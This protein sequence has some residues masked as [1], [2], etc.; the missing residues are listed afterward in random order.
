MASGHAP[1]K[2]QQVIFAELEAVAAKG[3]TSRELQKA[4]A[5]FRWQIIEMLDDPADI[6]EFLGVEH[7]IGLARSPLDRLAQLEAV[8]LEQVCTAARSVFQREGL[9]VIAVG[10]LPEEV[11]R[12]LEGLV[13]GF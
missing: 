9:S 7:L 4:K 3:V 5:R 10:I 6:A 1:S 13:V 2:A 12:N 11:Q 8:T